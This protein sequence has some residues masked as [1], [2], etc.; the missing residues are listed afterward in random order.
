VRTGRKSTVGIRI[1]IEMEVALVTMTGNAKRDINTNTGLLKKKNIQNARKGIV[2]VK[3][4]RKRSVRYAQ[5]IQ[6]D[7]EGH[8]L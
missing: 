7:V 3:R 4:K 8:L 2:I 6:K 1:N 5:E